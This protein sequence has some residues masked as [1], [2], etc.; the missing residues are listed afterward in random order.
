MHWVAASRYHGWMTLREIIVCACLTMLSTGP[1]LA[2]P[3]PSPHSPHPLAVAF[4]RPEPL[5]PYVT[6]RSHAPEAASY[7]YAYLAR[8]ECSDIIGILRRVGSRA[9]D[10]TDPKRSAIAQR[11][12]QRC[13]TFPARPMTG[14]LEETA[15]VAEGRKNGDRLF[16]G[17]SGTYYGGWFDITNPGDVQK[18]LAISNQL[19]DHPRVAWMLW[20]D[21]QSFGLYVYRVGDERISG[22]LPSELSTAFALAG[23]DLG[24]ECGPTSMMLMGWCIQNGECEAPSL[25]AYWR[26]LTDHGK[27]DLDWAKVSR[28]KALV[29]EA[30]RSGDWSRFSYRL[31]APHTP[32]K[33]E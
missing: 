8:W 11:V 22:K 18:A 20:Q 33:Q 17:F 24:A 23:C 1:C 12:K 13:D 2:Q 26:G 6:Q 10:S 31:P 16:A 15:Y 14:P 29:I 19:M 3:D 21:L 25:E 5:L 30:A 4:D 27:L 7:A 9:L 32:Q 28:Y